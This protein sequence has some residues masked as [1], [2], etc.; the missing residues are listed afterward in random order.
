MELEILELLFGSALVSVSLYLAVACRE[1]W[2]RG[3]AGN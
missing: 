3:T 2:R 1:E